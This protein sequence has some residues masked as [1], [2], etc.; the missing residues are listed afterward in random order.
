MSA[1]EYK[2]GSLSLAGTVAMGTGVMI[3]AGIFALTGQVAEFAGGLFPLAFLLAAIGDDHLRAATLV[4]QTGEFPRN[5]D[6]RQ[7]D[8]DNRRQG[9]ACEVIDD[10]ERPE[11]PAIAQ[12]VGDEVE[13]PSLVRPFG[14]VHRAAGT[15]RA[16]PAAPAFHGETFLLVDPEDLLVVSPQALAVEQNAQPT[17]TKPAARRSERPHTLPHDSIIACLFLILER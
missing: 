3:G 11:P 12:G 16:F 9:L 7:R 6:T 2:Q 10:A 17:V 13:A 4:D 14:E 5:A 1:K 8:I 15:D